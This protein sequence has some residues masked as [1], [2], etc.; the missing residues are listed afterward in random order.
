MQ[1]LYKQ[2]FI[3]FIFS[4]LVL[5]S[6][7]LGIEECDRKGVITTDD[8]PCRLLLPLNET[9]INCSQNTISVYTNGSLLLYTQSLER[10][11]FFNCNATFNQSSAGS[12]THFY[13]NGDNGS[14]IVKEGNKMIFLFYFMLALGFLF[15]ILAFWKEEEIFA[16][17]S[18]IIF[19]I[20]GVF[21]LINGF[22][23][24]VNLMT[25]AMG[26]VFLGMGAYIWI[27]TNIDS[28]KD[29]F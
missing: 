17:I 6:F 16:N 11:N 5:S 10:Y 7:V 4:L 29:A 23:N 21:V 25:I 28:F 27:R 3:F 20:M 18:G 22:Q 12:Y 14:I 26:S 15:L 8:V 2:V 19:M 13:S 24:I 9:E 1:D